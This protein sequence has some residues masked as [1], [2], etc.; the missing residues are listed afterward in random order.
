MDTMWLAVS[1]LAAHARSRGRAL[2]RGNEIGA[3]T[4]EWIVIAAALVAAVAVGAGI[5]RSAIR[6]EARKLP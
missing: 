4:L 3:L 2:F 1:Y 6:A 5:F